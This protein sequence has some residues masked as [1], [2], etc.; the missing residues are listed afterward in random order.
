LTPFQRDFYTESANTTNQSDDAVEEWKKEHDIECLAGYHDSMKG[1]E[2]EKPSWSKRWNEKES[3]Q[4]SKNDKPI[5]KPIMHFKDASFPHYI[6]SSIDKAGFD[7]P[8][9]IQSLTWPILLA[10]G[11]VIG[12]ARTGSGKTL[13]FLM[14]AMIHI[15]AQPAVKRGD[16]PVALVIAPTREL[17][18]QIEGEVIKF[19]SRIRHCCVYGGA[20]RYP[21][22][23]ALYGGVS[24][25]IATPG[26]LL[27]FIESGVTHLR[28]V[29]YCV[30]D[31]ADRLLDMGFE[32]QLNAIMNQ[33][34]PDRQMMMF[35]ATW[36]K[37]VRQLAKKYMVKDGDD[38]NVFQVAIGGSFSKLQ[39]NENVTQQIEFYSKTEKIEKLKGHIDDVVKADKEAKVLVFV[40]TK[41]M[42]NYLYENLW[43]DG[44]WA[45]CIHGDKQQSARDRALNDFKSGKMKILLA[46]DVASRG[47]HVDDIK[48]VINFDF[49]T[50]IED[51]VHR[52]GRTGRAGSKG[53]AITFFDTEEDAPRAKDLIKVLKDAKQEVPEKLY[54]YQHSKGGNKRYSRQ[55]FRY[56]GG[57]GG[58]GRRW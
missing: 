44:Y 38:S 48:L 37:D 58:G 16:G 55:R 25:I 7:A 46:T 49:P 22:K 2:D 30:I 19:A 53:T 10:G 11:D 39:A 18:V 17:A 36:P 32:P 3:N 40:A 23:K 34:R 1:T 45:T 26:R 24:I 28:R 29:T 33:I 20:S 12:I 13:S 43:Q 35:S 15:A 31:E 8:T 56:G 9:P 14:P 41:K 47:I 5:P 4:K 57:F 54:K 50:Q 42:T 21:Q 27:D 6:Q 51:Y 52:I